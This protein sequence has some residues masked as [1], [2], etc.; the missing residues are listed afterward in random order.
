MLQFM[1]RLNERR[2]VDDLCLETSRGPRFNE[3]AAFDAVPLV[4]WTANYA[5]RPGEKTDE[6]RR[7]VAAEI[8]R[9]VR[10]HE[11]NNAW[12]V[13]VLER[14]QYVAEQLRRMVWP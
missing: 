2:G 12:R 7:R 6:Y 3:F 14:G 11:Y 1:K 8:D 5:P 4:R 10:D 9:A 13:L